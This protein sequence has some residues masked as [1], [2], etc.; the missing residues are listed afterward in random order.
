MEYAEL[1]LA[2][3]PRDADSYS[4][5]LRFTPAGSEADVRPLGATRLGIAA[6]RAVHALIVHGIDFT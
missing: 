2:L 6:N 3:Y 4:V 5:E 1:E